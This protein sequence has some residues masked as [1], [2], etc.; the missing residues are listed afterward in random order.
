MINDDSRE[1]HR[2][3]VAT[4]SDNAGENV[5]KASTATREVAMPSCRICSVSS[6]YLRCDP[7][8]GDAVSSEPSELNIR[9]V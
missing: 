3:S 7:V 6:G 2:R 4:G 9:A 8:P 1:G 5:G